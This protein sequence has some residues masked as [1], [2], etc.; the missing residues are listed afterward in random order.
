MP[1]ET[2]KIIQ[3]QIQKLPDEWRNII[4]KGFWRQ[5]T[6]DIL[7][8]NNITQE[9]DQAVILSE[10]TLLMLGLQ[11]IP[12]FESEIKKNISFPK[13]QIDFT[14]TAIKKEVF[15][16]IE[17]IIEDLIN[18]QNKKEGVRDINAPRVDISKRELGQEQNT[19]DDIQKISR[20]TGVEITQEQPEQKEESV[21]PQKNSVITG[22]EHPE[23][24]AKESPVSSKLGGTTRGIEQRK[25]RENPLE[26][27]YSE[28][29]DP[30]R[31]PIA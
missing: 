24:I 4:A 25:A 7:K 31:E 6:L 19:V 9:K 5:K 18:N 27:G 10:A 22:I 12:E 1:Q 3:E 13:N 20:E 17:P 8:K 15:S 28:G 21:A 11:D 23:Q 14:L 2:E 16:L 29:E 30:Y 26:R